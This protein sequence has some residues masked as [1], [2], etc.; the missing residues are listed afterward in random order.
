MEESLL[1]KNIRPVA[2]IFMLGMSTLLTLSDGNIS[3]SEYTFIIKDQWV[4]LWTTLTISFGS[5]Y[6]TGRTAEKIFKI[7]GNNNE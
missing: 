4:T 7:K 6:A 1:T 2:F 3:V 5:V